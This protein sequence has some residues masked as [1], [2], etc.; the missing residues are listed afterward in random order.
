[1]F[2]KKR[3][4]SVVVATLVIILLAIVAAGILWFVVNQSSGGS[5]SDLELAEKCLDYDTHVTKAYR[6]ITHENSVQNGNYQELQFT[7][8]NG[9]K[10][11][12][13]V[14]VSLTIE[15]V[16]GIS[17]KNIGEIIF[18]DKL[19]PLEKITTDVLKIFPDDNIPENDP[20]D[21]AQLEITTIPIIEIE[22][23]YNELCPNSFLDVVDLENSGF[24]TGN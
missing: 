20:F 16:G 1:M 6:E 24:V 14:G 17:R 4:L 23:E 2:S 11:K 5:L 3:G 12:N 19:K 9:A 13:L 22:P 8:L 15:G 21:F 18:V 10:G 7:I